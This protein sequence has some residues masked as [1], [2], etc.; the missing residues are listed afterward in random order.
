MKTSWQESR[1]AETRAYKEGRDSACNLSG[2]W[3]DRKTKSKEEKTANNQ[4]HVRHTQIQAGKMLIHIIIIV[5]NDVLKRI[6]KRLETC[7][8]FFVFLSIKNAYFDPKSIL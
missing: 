8:I 1:R 2:S 5:I 6:F 4:A 3:G 7:F